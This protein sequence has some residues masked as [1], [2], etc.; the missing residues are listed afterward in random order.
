MH[1][2]AK[3]RKVY[4]DVGL[5]R[6]AVRQMN[7]A[8]AGPR[9]YEDGKPYDFGIASLDLNSTLLFTKCSVKK[10]NP[11]ASAPVSVNTYP[12]GKGSPVNASAEH[13]EA[14]NPGFVE[15]IYAVN[16]C[17]GCGATAD[18][19]GAAVLD[20]G[21]CHKR[22]YCSKECQKQHWT[23]AH[24]KFCKWYVMVDKGSAKPLVSMINWP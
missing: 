4:T 7:E 11:A 16:E 20:C 8:L 10:D 23:H 17:S 1:Y 13:L 19:N 15:S 18:K 22:K 12:P 9:A 5:M 6:D 2:K 14:A 3:M 24:K 21:G